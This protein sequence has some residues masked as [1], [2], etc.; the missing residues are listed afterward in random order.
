MRWFHKKPP[1][2]CIDS[3]AKL[4]DTIRAVVEVTMKHMRQYY[5]DTHR[6]W[7]CGAP[8]APPKE[9]K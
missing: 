5:E 3:K 9:K 1:Q 8:Y 6:C 4:I 7:N 2:C